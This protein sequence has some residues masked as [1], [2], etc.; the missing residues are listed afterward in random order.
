ML[1]PEKSL[2]PEV[3]FIPYSTT[4]LHSATLWL[5]F[6]E[7][8]TPAMSLSTL[9][10]P[11]RF[12]DLPYELRCKVYEIIALDTDDLVRPPRK[13]PRCPW[14]P[15]TSFTLA[16]TC[17]QIRAE[18]IPI[19]HRLRSLTFYMERPQKADEYLALRGRVEVI[20]ANLSNQDKETFF[21][22]PLVIHWACIHV[23]DKH[24]RIFVMEGCL[25]IKPTF[26]R[27]VLRRFPAFNS[28][29]FIQSYGHWDRLFRPRIE[30][31]M[32]IRNRTHL[33]HLHDSW[34][35]V[36]VRRRKFA[37]GADPNTHD[38][39]D[40][41]SVPLGCLTS[42]SRKDAPSL[43]QVEELGKI[44]TDQS[45]HWRDSDWED[46]DSDWQGSD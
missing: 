3:S 18:L 41:F 36:S 4:T 9:N 17:S 40:G 32:R 27:K 16:Y 11:F 30:V 8:C 35:G 38:A 29:Y 43:E 13:A 6:Q 22:R 19:L 25:P 21:S 42:W 20:A 5:I 10:V 39:E 23:D 2:Q 26:F 45:L 12:L 37:N 24:R 28:L 44:G 34:K 7:S 15:Y 31:C 1:S 33:G 14:Q 46:S